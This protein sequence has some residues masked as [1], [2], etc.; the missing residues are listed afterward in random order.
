MP[1]SGTTVLRLILNYLFNDQKCF[2]NYEY[3]WSVIN[4]HGYEKINNKNNSVI[5]TWRDP[6]DVLV[7]KIR[8]LGIKRSNHKAVMNQCQNILKNFNEIR[9]VEVENS[10]LILKYENWHDNFDYLFEVLEKEYNGKISKKVRDSVKS[11]FSKKSIIKKQ[12]EFKG[13]DQFN[14]D[15]HIHGN[16]VHSGFKQ[17]DKVFDKEQIKKI[18]NKLAPVIKYWEKLK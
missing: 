15:T 14:N 3:R 17:W 5:T 16:H 11:E 4:T 8:V 9:K 10:T 12:K 6:R 7:S 2:N 1:R 18:N 13:F